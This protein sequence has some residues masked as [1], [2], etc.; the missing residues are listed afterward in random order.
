M[1]KETLRDK[2]KRITVEDAAEMIIVALLF[3]AL[4]IYELYSGS[5]TLNGVPIETPWWLYIVFVALW[6]VFLL[7]MII[8]M[9]LIF[10]ATSKFIFWWRER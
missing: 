10:L 1:F 6:V 2:L 5:L 3:V 8:S 9:S 4:P 7:V